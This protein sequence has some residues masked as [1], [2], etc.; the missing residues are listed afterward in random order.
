VSSCVAM[1]YQLQRGATLKVMSGL[2]VTWDQLTGRACRSVAVRLNERLAG[3]TVALVI[4]PTV[5]V[6]CGQGAYSRLSKMVV[7]QKSELG[8]WANRLLANHLKPQR[9]ADKVSL[10]CIPIDLV[11]RR[12][13]IMPPNLTGCCIGAYPPVDLV[14]YRLSSI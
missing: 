3:V 11:V 5:L 9:A 13:A 8:A 14:L 12:G 7:E 2:W 10:L 1:G 4:W 6:F